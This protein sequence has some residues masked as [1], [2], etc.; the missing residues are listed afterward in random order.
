M[1][2][3]KLDG[4]LAHDDTLQDW[5]E[6]LSTVGGGASLLCLVAGMAQILSG[7]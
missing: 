1:W 2:V 5:V 3:V 4:A 6:E 7:R